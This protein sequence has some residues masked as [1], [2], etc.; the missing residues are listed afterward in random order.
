MVERTA[1]DDPKA[2]RGAAVKVARRLQ[3]AGHVAYFAGG[4][5]RDEL[6]G[7]TP[8]DYDVATSAKPDE[9]TALFPRARKVGEA[10][11]V[12]LVY[13]RRIPIEVATFRVEWGY[14]DHRHPSHVAFSDAEHDAR[15]RDFTING[16]FE[17]PLADD[18]ERRVIDYVGGRADLEAGLVRAIGD[19][20]ERFGEDYLRL[21]RA[22]RFAVRPG[23]ELE[24]ETA[25]AVR[26]LA[27]RLGEISR[28]RIGLEMQA[29]LTS[30]HPR[31]GV[32]LLQALGLDGPVLDEPARGDACPTVGGLADATAYPATLAAWLLDRHLWSNAADRGADPVGQL[33][34]FV[35]GASNQMATSFERTVARWRE[36][37]VLSNE[38]RDRLRAS[39]S[40]LPTMLKWETLSIAMKKRAMA[41][42]GWRE[43]LAVLR[44]MAGEA[45]HPAH[46][47]AGRALEAIDMQCDTLRAQGLTPDPLVTGHDLI[48][49]GLA[50]G[51]AFGRI[52]EEAYDLQLE[53]ELTSRRDALY[54]L[55][56]RF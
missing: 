18:P 17:D 39:I 22:V 26:M 20:A 38:D 56:G 15:R 53:G 37:L 12:M 42:P 19:P 14:D 46:N 4:C 7:L 25:S 41:S 21:L 5:V 13:V 10:F 8:K 32:A 54:W 28:E 49:L 52:L 33:E 1:N 2:A 50:P 9:V 6:L 3:E 27:P 40:L 30:A 16:L 55:E 29:I 48:K 51:P 23:F 47:A 36:A 35:A 43:G 31:E 34:G 44:A 24:A 45:S 11:G